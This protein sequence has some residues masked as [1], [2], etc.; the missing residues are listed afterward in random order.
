SVPRY[1]VRAAGRMGRQGR[2]QGRGD[3]LER[4]GGRAV[5]GDRRDHPRRRVEVGPRYLGQIQ[6]APLG[7]GKQPTDCGSSCFG[8]H[9][10][11]SGNSAVK[12]MVKK[13][14]MER[15]SDRSIAREN[16]TPTNF[17]AISSDSP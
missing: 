3:L 9:S 11:T 6:P 17:D 16:G 7:L 1:R 13:N 8:S 12:A 14:T 2:Q 4:G 10:T 5:Q 15:G